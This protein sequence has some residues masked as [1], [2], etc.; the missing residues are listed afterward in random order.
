[1]DLFDYLFAQTTLFFVPRTQLHSFTTDICPA[2]GPSYDTTHISILRL[3]QH[4]FNTSMSTAR[5]R[6]PLA[7][8]ATSSFHLNTESYMGR[9]YIVR[10]AD[11]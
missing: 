3:L 10:A 9:R 7:S 4:R 1:M 11:R 8:N 2:Q 6:K 5:H